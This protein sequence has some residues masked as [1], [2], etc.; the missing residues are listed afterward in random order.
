V[1][2]LVLAASLLAPSA[3]APAPVPEPTPPRA[4]RIVVEPAVF[5]FGKVV[6]ERTLT[7]QFSIRNFGSADLTILGISHACGCT[8][9]LMDSKVVKPGG[10]ANLRVTFETR[11]YAGKVSRSVL[12]KSND[13]ERQ[14]VELKLEATVTP[15][16]K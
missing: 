5:D 13:P 3:Q 7:K 2:A 4:P 11:N 1:R 12:V 14:T 6:P 9:S 8:A 10:N 16:K 15:D